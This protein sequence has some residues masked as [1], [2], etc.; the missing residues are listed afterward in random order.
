[1]ILD[2]IS[3]INIDV[4]NLITDI[5]DNCPKQFEDALEWVESN[6]GESWLNQWLHKHS[7][8]SNWV[9]LDDYSYQLLLDYIENNIDSYLNQ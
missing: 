1:M 3:H 8:S 9:E 5:I 6:N 7:N 4:E 2:V